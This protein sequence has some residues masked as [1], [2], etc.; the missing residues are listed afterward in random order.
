VK[1]FGLL[2]ERDTKDRTSYVAAS[3]IGREDDREYPIG[4]SDGLGDYE[5]PKHLQGLALD[6]LSIRGF[7]SNSGDNSFIGYD[8]EYRNV[9]SVDLPLARKMARTLDRI[10]KRRRKDAAYEPGDTL[11]SLAKVLKLEFVVERRVSKRAGQGSS[12]SESDWRWMTVEEG[13][14]RFRALIE[15]ARAE[16][17]ARKAA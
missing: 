11:M 3:L 2:I 4:I 16:E 12:W 8:P 6:G 7:V 13:R 10:T 15:E 9:Y 5:R 17:I 1:K 14:N